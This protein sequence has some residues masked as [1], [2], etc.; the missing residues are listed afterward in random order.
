MNTKLIFSYLR[1]PL[2]TF[3]CGNFGNQIMSI[4]IS[5]ILNI[6]YDKSSLFD[7]NEKNDA[8]E[9]GG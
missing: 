9:K 6:K 4:D 3:F 5:D 1:F 7:T 8:N 2:F